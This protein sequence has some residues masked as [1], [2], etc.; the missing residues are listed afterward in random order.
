MTMI[1]KVIVVEGIS[2][3]KRVKEVLNDQVHIVCTHGTMGV[4]K[5]DEMLEEMYGKQVY[6]LVDQDKE[7]KKI[8]Q[9]F[10]K[11]VSESEHIYVDSTFSEVARCPRQYLAN[12]LNYYGFKVNDDF[13]LKGKYRYHETHRKIERYIQAF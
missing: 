1:K 12:V 2:D 9:W 4:E 5:M 10:K 8:R 11:Y 13:V 6:V 7:G 3:K